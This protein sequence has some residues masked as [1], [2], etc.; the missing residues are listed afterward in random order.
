[1]DAEI[2]QVLRGFYVIDS[3]RMRWNYKLLGG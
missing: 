2:T 3:L 1:M